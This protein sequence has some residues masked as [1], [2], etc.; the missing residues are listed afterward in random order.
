MNN[1]SASKL[2]TAQGIWQTA[3]KS[4]SLLLARLVR[5]LPL[6]VGS[7]SVGWLKAVYLFVSFALAILKHQGSRGLAI[8]LKASALVLM[9][10]LAGKRLE[11]TRLSGTAISSSSSGYPRWI[12]AP[13]R[14]RIINGDSKVVRFYLG[15]CTLSRVLD[16]RGPLTIA[17]IIEPGV[18]ISAAWEVRWVKF[19]TQVFLP[20]LLRLGFKPLEHKR[21]PDLPG[22]FFPKLKGKLLAIF[23][24]G[25][26][27]LSEK[28]MAVGSF[29]KDAISLRDRP[30]LWMVMLNLAKEMGSMGIT[31]SPIFYLALGCFT[32]PWCLNH[33]KLKERFGPEASPQGEVGRLSIREEPG[34]MRVFAMVDSFTQSLLRPLH[35]FLF[36]ILKL[37][38]QDGTFNQVAPLKLLIKSM[39]ARK[40][41][42]VWSYDLSAATDRIPVRVQELLLAIFTTKRFAS[43]WRALLCDRYYR[44]PRSM[45]TTWGYKRYGTAVKYKVGQPMGAYSSWAMLALVHHALVQ[46]AAYSAGHRTWFPDYA[47]LGDDVV[48]GDRNVAKHYV[49]LMTKLGVKIGFHKS[50]ISNNLSL[51]FAK[52][53]V[54]KGVEVT[55]MPLLA[56]ACGWL[57]VSSIPEVLRAAE[58]LGS[59]TLSSFKIGRFAGVGLRQ[60]SKAGNTVITRLTRRLRSLLV[61]LSHPGAPRGC[62]D[63]WEWLRLKTFGSKILVPAHKTRELLTYLITWI[64]DVRLPAL[65][66]VLEGQLNNMR[67]KQSVGS[68]QL[69]EDYQSWF[70]IHVRLP[71][72]Q[73]FRWQSMMIETQ[74]QKVREFDESN[75]EDVN[76]L[77]EMVDKLESDIQAI[78]A[79]ISTQKRPEVKSQTPMFRSKRVAYWTRLGEF[80][81]RPTNRSVKRKV[82]HNPKFESSDV[83]RLL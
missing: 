22:R 71:L 79:E 14:L 50:I 16:F 5:A 72:E 83:L 57:G 35:D 8:H 52:R 12:P 25:P 47:V 69:E 64:D 62:A 77:L 51:E 15:L 26:N 67:P 53:F 10:A 60:A 70:K 32:F 48:I 80:V 31:H 63:L 21:D 2:K 7:N 66:A 56:I 36:G 38:P 23:S 55:P 6:V 3:V 41:K 61:L 29:L 68:G 58:G 45:L 59:F 30:R 27:F 34:K 1:F 37:I 4:R 28:Q 13:M 9:R 54:W 43:R 78:P 65:L 40:L 20:Y 11:N 44:L 18:P 74:V 49:L 46:F 76:L 42:H 17:S 39:Q 19:V 82:A 75:E 73:K 33:T 81:A 24:N